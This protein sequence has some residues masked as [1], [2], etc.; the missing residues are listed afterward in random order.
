MQS[1]IYVDNIKSIKQELKDEIKFNNI[2]Y[3]PMNLEPIVK[4]QTKW[5]DICTYLHYL[6]PIHK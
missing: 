4:Q 5:A 3:L 1:K 2:K 6:Y